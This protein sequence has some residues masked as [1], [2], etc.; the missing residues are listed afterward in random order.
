MAS[1]PHTP[2]PG[3]GTPVG[4]TRH[5]SAHTGVE[6]MSSWELYFDMLDSRINDSAFGEGFYV[7]TNEGYEHACPVK[8]VAEAIDRGTDPVFL[9]RV[10][11]FAERAYIVSCTG[12]PPPPGHYVMTRVIHRG[13]AAYMRGSTG[14]FLT[15]LA[16]MP[17]PTGGEYTPGFCVSVSCVRN[18][19]V[20]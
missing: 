13:R 10:Q 11:P 17:V 9:H 6:E 7:D 19:G 14:S 15:Q 12:P 3:T 18:T 20:F 2:V 5:A 4:P 16:E 8:H 1:P